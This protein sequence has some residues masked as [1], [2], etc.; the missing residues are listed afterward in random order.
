MPINLPGRRTV[1][2]SFV[3]GLEDVFVA[4]ITSGRQT[5]SK[6]FK[7]V[8]FDVKTLKGS[9]NDKICHG[10]IIQIGGNSD[11]R[12]ED[13]FVG[14]ADLSLFDLIRGKRIGPACA[15]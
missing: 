14:L 1:D 13:P 7:N 6:L 12:D 3:M 2:T 4:K 9:L 5:A 15:G 10:S 11:L 8:P